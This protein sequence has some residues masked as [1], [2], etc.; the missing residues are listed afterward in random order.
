MN[1][2]ISFDYIGNESKTLDSAIWNIKEIVRVKYDR[3]NQEVDIKYKNGN[4]VSSC[5]YTVTEDVFNNQIKTPLLKYI[6]M[7]SKLDIV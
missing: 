3:A 1:F 6:E 2:F 7:D 5:F 4:G